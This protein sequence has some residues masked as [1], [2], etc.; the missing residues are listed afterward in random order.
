MGGV[1]E[2]AVKRAWLCASIAIAACHLSRAVTRQPSPEPTPSPTLAAPSPVPVP[3]PVPAPAPAPPPPHHDHADDADVALPI[4]DRPQAP[5]SPDS[6]WCGETAIQEALLHLGVWAPQKTIHA[7]AKP[8]HSDLYSNDIPVALAALGIP[9]SFYAPKKKGFDAYAAW[10]RDAIDG[11]EPV[12]AGVKILPTEHPDWGLD[13]FVLAIGYGDDGL[14]VNTTWGRRE[15]VG[16]TTTPGLSL[17]A[18]FYAIA[19]HR[20]ADANGARAARLEVIEESATL[21]RVRVVCLDASSSGVEHRAGAK[22]QSAT[23]GDGAI[24]ISATTVARFRCA[25]K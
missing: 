11:G 3:V 17:H 8:K 19:V 16:D 6:G 4:P 23:L 9:H 20:P 10:V 25:A 5:E 14:L 21:V 1:G 22:W 24:T 12:I 13:H 15:W 2:G 7:V 18:A